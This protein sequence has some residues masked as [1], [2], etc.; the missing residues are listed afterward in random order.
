MSEKMKTRKAVAKRFKITGTGKVMHHRAR[1]SHLLSKMGS[2]TKRQLKGSKEIDRS[3][4]KRVKQM[5][6]YG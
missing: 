6:P 5:M 1:K 2:D 3:D 4:F